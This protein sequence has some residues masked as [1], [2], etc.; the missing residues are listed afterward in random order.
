MKLRYAVATA[1]LVLVGCGTP[2]ETAQLQRTAVISNTQ[3]ALV[4][5]P[6][7]APTTAPINPSPT[8]V[9]TTSQ[10]VQATDQGVTIVATTQSAPTV[11]APNT[12]TTAP[13]PVAA[14]TT[15]P[16]PPTHPP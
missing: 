13:P 4:A 12:P 16:S 11:P 8:L 1:D 2:P 6:S 10:A 14:P 7:T 5:T 3:L 15:L 9:I